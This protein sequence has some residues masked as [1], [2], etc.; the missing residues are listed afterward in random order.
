MVIEVGFP[1]DGFRSS[2]TIDE[3]SE[4][5]FPSI[6]VARHSPEGESAW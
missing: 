2:F 5:N 3:I 4:E 6:A 1:P